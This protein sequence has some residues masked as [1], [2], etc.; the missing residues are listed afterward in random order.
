AASDQ[1]RL[2]GGAVRRGQFPAFADF[3]RLGRHAIG[4]LAA[5]EAG[6]IPIDLVLALRRAAI[7]Q[8]LRIGA[9]FVDEDEAFARRAGDLDRISVE[10]RKGIG[11]RRSRERN[12]RNEYTYYE[13]HRILPVQSMPCTPKGRAWLHSRSHRKRHVPHPER[14]LLRNRG[15]ALLVQKIESKPRDRPIHRDEP[16]R[17]RQRDIG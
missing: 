4:L 7:R 11:K 5:E 13:T 16:P 15:V 6:G 1:R 14:A 17:R 8:L 3:T 10:I 12:Q 9:A 2:L